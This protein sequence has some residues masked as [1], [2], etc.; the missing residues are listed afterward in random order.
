M[1][2][3]PVKEMPVT[4]RMKTMLHPVSDP[5]GMRAALERMPVDQELENKFD[6]L[7]EKLNVR[8]TSE[9]VKKCAMTKDE[10]QSLST[11]Q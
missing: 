1:E 3:I 2:T 9:I 5:P 6:L 7:F 11:I 10:N 4:E 8:N